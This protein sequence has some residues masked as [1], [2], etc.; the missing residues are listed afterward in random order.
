MTE[1]SH[2][3]VAHPYFGVFFLLFFSAILFYGITVLAR[4]ISR[5]MARSD[6]EKLKLSIY[7]CGP[8]VSKQ[9]NKISVHFYLFAILFIVFEIEIIFM[10]PWAV[11]FYTLGWFGFVQ[12]II[13]IALLTIGF[14]YDWKKGALEW[15]SIK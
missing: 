11:N 4:F 5:K 13:F 6:T 8:E 10:Y 15:H 9:P 12:I 1:L 2:V 7:E 3:G 14:L